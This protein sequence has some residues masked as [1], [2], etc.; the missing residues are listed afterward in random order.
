MVKKLMVFTALVLIL[1]ACSTTE[2]TTPLPGAGTGTVVTSAD[3]IAGITWQWNSM[4]ET[5]PP[6]LNVVPNPEDYTLV[7]QDNGVFN[8]QADCNTAAG[9]YKLE[10]ESLVMVLGPSTKAFCGEDSLD[11]EYQMLINKVASGSIAPDGQLWLYLK[12]SAGR[13]SFTNGGPAP[14]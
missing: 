2:A 4:E 8:I 11:A 13:M 12:G 7:F 3:Q 10:Y 9:T 5:S 6:T 1:A 14:K